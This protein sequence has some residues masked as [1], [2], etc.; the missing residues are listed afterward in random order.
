MGAQITPRPLSLRDYKVEHMSGA[1]DPT[2]AYAVN[3]L[4]SLEGAKSYL[5]VFSGSGTLLVK[6]HNATKTFKAHWF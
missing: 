2:I 6:L 3:S 4:A 5:N 1:M